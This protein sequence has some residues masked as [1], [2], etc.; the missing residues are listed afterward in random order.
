MKNLARIVGFS[1]AV[2][3]ASPA[4]AQTESET[5]KTPMFDVALGLSTGYLRRFIT[6]SD[7][8]ALKLGVDLRL[9]Y[10]MAQAGVLLEVT[11]PFSWGNV[12]SVGGMLGVQLATGGLRI[13]LLGAVGVHWYN[14]AGGR[15]VSPGEDVPGI[16]ATIPF[17]GGRIGLSW[18]WRTVRPFGLGALF[19]MDV[20]LD[21]FESTYTYT[22][23]TCTRSCP[24]VPPTETVTRTVAFG[25]THLGLLLR[26]YWRF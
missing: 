22:R 4:W 16:G 3:I 17:V 6:P 26:V 14:D 8:E 7:Q 5:P 21:R 2:A 24:P 9:R 13:D 19:L 25:E 20:D 18:E 12:N 1:L 15:V 23:D 11:T 10:G